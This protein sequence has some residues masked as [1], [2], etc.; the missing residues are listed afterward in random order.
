MGIC[1][2]ILLCNWNSFSHL[3]ASNAPCLSI[4]FQLLR[5]IRYISL[6]CQA[7][8]FVGVHDGILHLEDKLASLSLGLLVEEARQ[9]LHSLFGLVVL[10]QLPLSGR[11]FR[12][13]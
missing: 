4:V 9:A 10:Q 6:K 5:V 1:S 11:M 13:V 8:T 3:S 12:L 7:N 2:F